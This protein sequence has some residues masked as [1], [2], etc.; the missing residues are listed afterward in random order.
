MTTVGFNPRLN[1]DRRY[2]TKKAHI[3]RE[4]LGNDKA[5]ERRAKISPG[6]AAEEPNLNISETVSEPQV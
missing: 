1:S 4:S 3:S 6:S 5:L 2:A